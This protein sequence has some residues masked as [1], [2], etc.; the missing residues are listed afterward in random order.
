MPLL[1]E[2]RLNSNCLHTTIVLKVALRQYTLETRHLRRERKRNQS[3]QMPKTSK[4]FELARCNSFFTLCVCR[5]VFF[6]FGVPSQMLREPRAVD[7][8]LA[9]GLVIWP[10]PIALYCKRTQHLCKSTWATPTNQSNGTQRA[11]VQKKGSKPKKKSNRVPHHDSSW[12]YKLCKII[13]FHCKF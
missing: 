9:H 7:V 13:D 4:C 10:S 6:L 3:L 5:Y 11:G 12:F 8:V 2:T 1:N